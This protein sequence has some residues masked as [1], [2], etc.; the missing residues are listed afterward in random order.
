MIRTLFEQSVE[1]SPDAEF[2]VF[3][4]H[5]IH[6]IIALTDLSTDSWDSRMRLTMHSFREPKVLS[7][8]QIVT[9]NTHTEDFIFQQNAIPTTGRGSTRFIGVEDAGAD[10][11]HTV[12]MLW[13]MQVPFLVVKNAEVMRY[14]P[15]MFSSVG[16]T[17]LITEQHEVYIGSSAVFVRVGNHHHEVLMGSDLTYT[18]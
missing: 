13:T 12:D 4:T 6:A 9:R 7:N 15:S 14:P 11:R 16:G 10:W 1:N 18:I 3:D 8:R 17:H 5:T 2:K